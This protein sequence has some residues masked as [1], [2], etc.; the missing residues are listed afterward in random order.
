MSKINNFL[1]NLG[2]LHESHS[3]SVHVAGYISFGSVLVLLVLFILVVIDELIFAAAFREYLS[4]VGKAALGGFGLG[5][6][7]VVLSTNEII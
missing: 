5:C 7:L 4:I 6:V 1:Y 2:L 3:K